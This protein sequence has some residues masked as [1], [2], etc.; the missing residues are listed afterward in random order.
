M[1]TSFRASAMRATAFLVPAKTLFILIALLLLV[2]GCNK[3][4][5][6][7][8]ESIQ[9]A[10]NDSTLH[11]TQT[12]NV[13]MDIL[14]DGQR[15]IRINSPYATTAET[16]EGG[17]TTLDGPLSIEVRD[18]LGATQTLVTADKAIYENRKGTFFLM[19]NVEVTT[20]NDQILRSDELTWFQQE[21]TIY[22][23]APV[24]LITARDSLTG[25][26]LSGDDQLLEYTIHQ[27][28]GR[29][30]LD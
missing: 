9:Q 26:G 10:L 4:S 13:T 18:S 23:E 30:T 12:W 29:F 2:N 7:D 22:T 5:E 6:Y 11:A 25:T 24:T 21:R 17:E 8:R 28:T 14:Q 27:V 20:E 19:G 16:P 1:P 15:F 3:L